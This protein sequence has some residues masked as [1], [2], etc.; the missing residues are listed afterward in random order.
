MRAQAI[1]GQ[2]A[3]RKKNAP[4]KIRHLKHVAYCR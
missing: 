2:Y 3:Q 1:D 4:A